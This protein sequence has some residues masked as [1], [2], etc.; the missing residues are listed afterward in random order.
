LYLLFAAA[1][2]LEKIFYG[3]DVRGYMNEMKR[4]RNLVLKS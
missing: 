3:A 4:V 2:S 1:A